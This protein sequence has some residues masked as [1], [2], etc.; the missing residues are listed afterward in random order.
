MKVET[1]SNEYKAIFSRNIGVMSESDQ[2][3]LRE[4]CIAIAGMGGVG[5]LLAERLIRL[6]VGHLK[7]TDPGYFEKSNLNRQLYSSTRNLNQNKAEVLYS[8]LKDINPEADIDWSDTGIKNVQDANAFTNTQVE[9]TPMLPW[10]C[11]PANSYSRFPLPHM[12]IA[13]AEGGC[14]KQ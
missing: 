13:Y 1:I 14:K 9:V 2:K 10:T 12:M 6:G 7:I 11:L 3:K 8:H 4:S 5:G